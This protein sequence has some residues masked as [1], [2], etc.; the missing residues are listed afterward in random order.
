MIWHPYFFHDFVERLNTCSTSFNFHCVGKYATMIGAPRT[1]MT[2]FLGA[3]IIRATTWHPRSIFTSKTFVT[4]FSVQFVQ[5]TLSTHSTYGPKPFHT[6]KYH[7][8]LLP[9]N[10]SSFNPGDRRQ[11]AQPTLESLESKMEPKTKPEK[12]CMIRN[13]D[14][15]NADLPEPAEPPPNQQRKPHWN[16]IWAEPPKPTQHCWEKNVSH[17][18]DLVPPSI[19]TCCS[20]SGMFKVKLIYCEMFKKQ[21]L[22][23]YGTPPWLDCLPSKSHIVCLPIY[24]KSTALCNTADEYG[25]YTVH[26]YYPQGIEPTHNCLVWQKT[27][28][29]AWE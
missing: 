6:K 10:L 5:A 29:T 14:P 1:L 4:S 11:T 25:V 9:V 19:D 18:S 20:I 28:M 15:Y 24:S 26:M 2:P 27:H 17:R 8:P 23:L 12:L 13:K 22:Q 3:S 21:D 16:I 7:T